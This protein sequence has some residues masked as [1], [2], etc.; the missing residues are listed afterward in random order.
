MADLRAIIAHAAKLT[1][2]KPL[3]EFVGQ[4]HGGMVGWWDGRE[5]R[6]MGVGES[7]GE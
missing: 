2:P 1:P 3:A 4:S 5:D 7:A 6:S